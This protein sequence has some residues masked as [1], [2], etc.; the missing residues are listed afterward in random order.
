MTMDEWLRTNVMLMYVGKKSWMHFAWRLVW[1]WAKIYEYQK[2]FIIKNCMNF[3]RWDQAWLRRWWW[4]RQ[5][6]S[7]CN[8]SKPQ[9]SD[10]FVKYFI[11]EFSFST[12]WMN[13]G[14]QNASKQPDTECNCLSKLKWTYHLEAQVCN[15]NE[16]IRKTPTSTDET[17]Q[18]II[19]CNHSTSGHSQ[20]IH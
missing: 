19:N 17:A 11:K 9:T 12:K 6:H 4:Q 20:Y 3:S 10:F 7:N 15:G 13:G 16:N 8:A 2:Q 1:N 18:K 5:R 14:S